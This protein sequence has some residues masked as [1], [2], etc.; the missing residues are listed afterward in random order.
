MEGS[1]WG[2][3]AAAEL[4]LLFQLCGVAAAWQLL[5][6]ES[7][8][9]RV[10]LGSLCGSLMLQWFPALFAFPL[11]FS[12]PTQLLAA[13]LA[14]ACAGA[15]LWAGRRKSR[16]PGGACLLEGAK[17]FSRHRFLFLVLLFS[18]FYVFLVLHS[19][20][21]VNGR[22]Y[23]C[24]STYGDMSMHLSF[25]T[26]LARQQA[27]PPEYSLLPGNRL[28][29]PFL[30]DSISASLYLLGAPLRFSYAL[31]MWAAGAQ[32]F[33]GFYLFARRLLGS[34]GKAAFAWVLFFGNGGLGVLYF[35]GDGWEG[36]SRIF[37]EFYQTPTNLVG[38][39]IR[40][41]NVVADMMLPQ[42]ATLFGWAVLFPALYVLY[43]AVF[44]GQRRY[45]LYAGVLAGALP[46]VHTH[47]F[48]A[49]ALVCGAWMAFSLCKGLGWQAVSV[50]VGKGAVALGF[51]LMCLLKGFL[52]S[53]G[54]EDSPWLLAAACG[55]LAA[56]L[57]L[58]GFLV[59]QAAR[60]GRGRDLLLPWALLAGAACLLAFPQLFMWTFRQAGAGGFVRGHFGWVTGED[61]YLWFYLK[62]L[63][64]SALLAFLGL[65]CCKKDRFA[66]YAPALV[67]WALAEFVEFQP[68]DYDNNKLLYVAFA[69]LCVCAADFAADVLGKVR[70]A[71]ARRALA[72]LG[73]VFLVAPAA[74]TWGREAVAEYELYGD[75]ALSLCA[76]IEEQ[77]PPDA[78]VLTDLR[79]NNEVASLT[80]RNVVCGS[81]SYLFYHG[82]PYSGREY[83]VREMYERPLESAGLYRRTGAQYVL[84]SDFER[85]SY[86]VDGQA[87]DALFPV[88]YDDGGRKL[89]Q[90]DL[91]VFERKER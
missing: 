46:M 8:G 42:R 26:S 68:N 56:C 21:S 72:G 27:F 44:E 11:G 60:R 65:L 1:F 91:D 76:Y 36:F 53:R 49:L 55:G 82:L 5:P 12:L 13:A 70:R 85:S 40:W 63:G 19:F 51:P 83:A 33:F 48:L 6:K 22:V 50:R 2:G 80:G 43:R 31:P 4:F 18:G 23:S 64:L 77:L 57:A 73:V 87:L 30:S 71:G 38:Q 16:R 78:V 79:H 75:G 52:H 14:L 62:N 54:L 88:V 39:N 41:V 10:L 37:T 3:V 81:P 34:D 59:F 74:L 15:S 9:A 20:Q 17:A 35:L 61:G 24:Q 25:I 29:Y 86:Q 32:V 67:I 90:V 7:A 45:F 84:V 89:Y 66:R 58:L 47:S 69:L 28:S